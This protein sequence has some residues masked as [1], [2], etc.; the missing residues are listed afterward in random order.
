MPP[1]AIG[2]GPGLDLQSSKQRWPASCLR[3]D[4]LLQPGP[5]GGRTGLEMWPLHDAPPLGGLAVANWPLSES[6]KAPVGCGRAAQSARAQES[7]SASPC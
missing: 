5:P 7:R 4:N 1:P 2:L 6:L 3:S